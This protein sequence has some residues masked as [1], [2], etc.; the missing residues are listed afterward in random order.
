MK[1][2]I[3]RT[4]FFGQS[5][6]SN[7]VKEPG[8]GDNQEQTAK[9][10]WTIQRWWKQLN[11]KQTVVESFHYVHDLVSL[12]QAKL[13]SFSQLEHFVLDPKTLSTTKKLLMHLE[14]TKD[15]ILPSRISLSNM[16]EAEREFLASYM[17]ATKSNYLFES[18]NDFDA[19]LLFNAEQM[20]ESFER[21]CTLMKEIYLDEL[22]MPASPLAAQTPAADKILSHFSHK[23]V[24]LDH[25]FMEQGRNFLDDF[26]SKQIAYYETF[27]EWENN[28]RYK[29][30]QVLIKKYTDIERKRFTTLYSLDPRMLELYEHYGQQQATL[31][32]GIDQLLAEEGDLK[33]TAALDLLKAELEAEKWTLRPEESL[34]HELALNPELTLPLEVCTIKPKKDVQAAVDALLHPSHKLDLMVH[35]FDEIKAKLLL[36]TPN[37]RQQIKELTKNFE[38]EALINKIES[39][40]LEKGIHLILCALIQEIRNLESPAHNEETDLFLDSLSKQFAEAD[41]DMGSAL[42]QAVEFIYRKLSLINLE[43]K[44]FHL[45]QSRELI[46]RTIFAVEQQKFQEHLSKKQFNLHFV[47]HWL[48]T[49]ISHPA[50][51]QLERPALCSKYLGTYTAHALLI[52]VLQDSS[53]SILHTIPETFYLDRIRLVDWHTQYQALLYTATALGYVETFCHDQGVVLSSELLIQEKNRLL[54]LLKAGELS[55]TQEKVDDL[56]TAINHLLKSSH[57]ELSVN[58]SKSLSHLIESSC[59]GSSKVGQLLN[60]RLG[61]QLSFYLFRGFLPPHPLPLLKKYDLTQD[62]L[63][64]GTDIRPVLRLHTQ[65]HE[66]FYRQQMELRLWKPLYKALKTNSAPASIGLIPFNSELFNS[67]YN[68]IHKFA[69]LL[70]SLV[71]IQ[72]L[73][74]GSDMWSSNQVVT[75][76]EL[77]E[78]AVQV[79]LM[80]M[81]ADDT[82]TKEMM[83]LKLVEAMEHM[84]QSKGLPFTEMDK[85]NM[86]RMLQL[87]S[88]E[89]SIGSKCFVDDLI[90]LGKH[91]SS[92]RG[93]NLTFKR[94]IAEFKSEAIEVRERIAK[95]IETSKQAHLTEDSN[96]VASLIPVP[97][98]GLSLKE[99]QKFRIN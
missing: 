88:D 31:K 38:R 76:A 57:K 11:L 89:K 3:D 28:N 17:I 49:F 78:L 56:S 55:T 73:V 96:P 61:S 33:L 18:A 30:A 52:A 14:Q 4:S 25:L 77:K 10:A 62:L 92:G 59:E 70:D 85:R 71:L 6:Y 50:D 83:S 74:I 58:D 40:G 21:L 54:N 97:R 99:T 82:C 81:L 1:L 22:D 47:F 65:V 63:A 5:S 13:E 15:I 29:L 87:S 36:F 7:T 32:K 68:H 64:I 46:G 94:F 95:L 39:L 20:L 80:A 2:Q 90:T 67:T 8:K 19:L 27:L 72:Q 34:L 35:V 66:G 45:N 93:Q 48:D 69:F 9:A 23:R 41:K 16:Y 44:N 51:Y 24:Q 84:A 43:V 75:Y 98:S 86:K 91:N 37:N 12:E 53:S 26:H 60:K 79:G 42:T